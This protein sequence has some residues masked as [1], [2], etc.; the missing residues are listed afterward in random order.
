MSPGAEFTL[1]LNGVFLILV[2]AWAI[3][4]ILRAR[5]S[6][7]GSNAVVENLSAR[8]GAWWAIAALLALAMLSGRGGVVVLFGFISFAALREFLTL[9]AK[10]RADHWALMAAFFLI[11][12]LQYVMVY[13]DWYRSYSV[14]IPVYAFLYLPVLSVL[15]GGSENFLHRVSESQW[16]LMICVYAASHVPALLTLDISGFEGRNILLI[17]FLVIIVQITDVLQYVWSQLWGRHPIAA[18]LSA[19]KTWEGF[20]GAVLSGGLLGAGMWWMTPFSPVAAMVLGVIISATGLFG[21]LVMS[22]IKRDKGVRDWGH[23]VAGQGG[24]IDRLDG[25][26]FAAPVFF[27]LARAFWATI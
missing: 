26:V 13:M 19:S 15:R 4:A 24:F 10:S 1:L 20:T 6:P 12:P 14:F 18:S 17:A 11:L 7:D 3:A 23:L 5:L 16:A 21:A 2:V 9:T 8:I 25:V 22:A 27:H